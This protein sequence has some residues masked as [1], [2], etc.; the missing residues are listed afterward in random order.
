MVLTNAGASSVTQGS[1]GP[2]SM[3]SACGNARDLNRWPKTVTNPTFAQGFVQQLFYQRPCLHK[4]L[5]LL[6]ATRKQ[7]ALIN[8]RV[9]VLASWCLLVNTG[10]TLALCLFNQTLIE[11]FAL[12]CR[13]TFGDQT[14][15]FIKV[16]TH[17]MNVFVGTGNATSF[18]SCVCARPWC[19]STDPH[20]NPR[21]ALNLVAAPRVI[22][23][24][25]FE[26]F[27]IA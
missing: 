11:G 14:H 5:I 17:L 4:C 26:R 9:H 21:V 2:W 8:Q 13:Q 27:A 15:P 6:N 3:C 19:P 23:D 1:S 10:Q 20:P 25:R 7:P 16:A 18:N 12:C 22:F 24:E